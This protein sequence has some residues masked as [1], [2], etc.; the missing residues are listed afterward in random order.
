MPTPSDASGEKRLIADRYRLDRAIGGGAMGTVWAATDELLRREVAVKEIRLPPHLPEEEAAELR[1]RALREARAIAVLTHPNVVTLY[2]VAR[3]EGE[4]YVVMELVPSQSLAAVLNK[5]GALGEA[6]LALITDGVA[7]ALDAAHRA[8]IIHRDVKPGNVLLGNAEQVKLSDFG[9]SRNIAES[10]LTRSGIMLGTPAFIAPEIASG[11]PVTASADLWGLGATLFAAAEGRPPYD[12]NNDALATVTSVVHDPVPE[13]TVTGPIADVI[14]GL[15]VKE[16]SGRMPLHEV[17][18]RLSRL[19]PESGSR[20]FDMLLDPEAPTVKVRRP[21]A[22]ARAP[23]PT[24]PSASGLRPSTPAPDAPAPSSPLPSNTGPHTAA[25]LASDPGPLPFM[26]RDPLPEPP[27]R[28]PRAKVALVVTA[29]LVFAAAALG[30]FA[31]SRVLA[32]EPV[33]PT[34]PPQ[35][36]PASPALRPQRWTDDATHTSDGSGPS[37]F[38]ISAPPEW[39]VFHSE[40]DDFTNSLSVHFVS[41]DGSREI[42]VERFGGFHSDGYDTDDYVAVL[43]ELAAGTRGRLTIDSDERLADGGEQA[44]RLSYTS[45][46]TGI[47]GSSG[48]GELVRVTTADLLRRGD[49]MWIVRVTVPSTEDAA[50]AKLFARVR[51]SF[52]AVA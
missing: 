21:A 31:T 29:V 14:T 6:Q 42:V 46:E 22:T 34:S 39:T 8:G 37:G 7:A 40:R 5:H 25:P 20:P 1:E 36:H 50:G 10:T 18:R 30:G 52:K 24:T 48:G 47:I 33:L 12:T 44:R 9:I 41:P 35:T 17:R 38:E 43:P 3:E 13:P 4:P 28:S 11:D 16:P 45:V 19:L 2:D 15:M 32:G 49:D 51:P 27:R 26:L 23:R